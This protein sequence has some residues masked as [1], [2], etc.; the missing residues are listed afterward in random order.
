MFVGS[1]SFS[2]YAGFVGSVSHCLLGV[3]GGMLERKQLTV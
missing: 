1:G 3:H 2:C